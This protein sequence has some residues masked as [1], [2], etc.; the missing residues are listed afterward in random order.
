MQS[1]SHF[2]FIVLSLFL[3]A[4]SIKVKSTCSWCFILLISGSV[5][6]IILAI[7]SY[8]KYKKKLKRLHDKGL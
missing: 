5:L 2:R 6:L 4:L 7:V 3:I 1:S 8:I